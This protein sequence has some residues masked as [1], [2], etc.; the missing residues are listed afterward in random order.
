MSHTIRTDVTHRFDL[1]EQEQFE[2]SEW[3]KAPLRILSVQAVITDGS[4]RSVQ[5][6]GRQV[7][8]SGGLG[9]VGYGA[10]LWKPYSENLKTI[11]RAHGIP[12][13]S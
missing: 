2:H 11:L 3:R 12:V 7:L 1:T 4:L 13:S 10:L 6:F 9:N 8:K 5:V